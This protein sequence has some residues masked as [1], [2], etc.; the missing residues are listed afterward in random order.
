MTT[1]LIIITVVPLLILAY[2]RFA[3]V[4]IDVVHQ[5]PVTAVASGK[6]NEYRMTS[7]VFDMI[8]PELTKMFDDFVLSQPRVKRIAGTVDDQMITYV[9]RTK[10][11]SYPDYITV[12]VV[13]VG[14]KQSRLE[15]FSR[16]RFGYSDLGVNKRRIDD[17]LLQLGR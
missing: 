3:P 10:I 13:P 15:I 16:S 11:I 17:W 4:N 1:V 9:Q 14:T 2:V 12:K 6:P 5:D 8:T 7:P